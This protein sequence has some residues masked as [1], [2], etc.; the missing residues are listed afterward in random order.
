MNVPREPPKKEL[1][2]RAWTTSMLSPSS[3]ISQKQHWAANF[4]PSKKAKASAS[5]TES[6]GL[7][8]KFTEKGAAEIASAQ[9]IVAFSNKISGVADSPSNT[10]LFL[11]INRLW[12]QLVNRSSPSV[13]IRSSVE[14][15]HS[16]RGIPDTTSVLSVKGVKNY[17]L[18]AQTQSLNR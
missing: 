2:F 13:P 18:L 6:E 8:L 7:V 17:N 10:N 15:I 1:D 3:S 12:R 4:R 16:R 9:E 5:L 14:M 11:A